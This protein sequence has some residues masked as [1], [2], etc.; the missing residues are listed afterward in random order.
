MAMQSPEGA[1]VATMASTVKRMGE[2]P[3]TVEG[4]QRML[5]TVP[6]A[7][8]DTKRLGLKPKNQ[9]FVAF[10][11][12][13]NAHI[14]A[15]EV[16]QRFYRVWKAWKQWCPRICAGLDRYAKRVAA[17]SYI[18]VRYR[19]CLWQRWYA[20]CRKAII[21][22]Q[23]CWRGY[24]VRKEY[25]PIIEEW[26]RY[27]ARRR[28]AGLLIHDRISRYWMIYEAKK[29][30]VRLRLG[31]HMYCNDQMILA[32]HVQRVQRGVM[33]RQF[34]SQFRAEREAAARV[35]QFHYRGRLLWLRYLDW[36][37]RRRLR[38]LREN[39][40]ARDIQ[41]IWRGHVAR[42]Y[43]KWLFQTLSVRNS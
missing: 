42:T 26:R 33:A 7:E 10:E 30:L 4:L 31:R 9:H 40:A 43:A 22:F 35:I 32:L 21:C 18:Q 5:A 11:R 27:L 20:R 24:L 34:A 39:Q 3:V 16:L 28:A 13:R 25:H 19:G 29:D 38:I 8:V 6:H 41:R 36:A 17:A 23:S 2:A 14:R 1:S 12:T 37:E 15:A